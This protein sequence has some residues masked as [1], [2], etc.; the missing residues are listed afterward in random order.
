MKK[1]FEILWFNI[2]YY[3]VL[4]HNR[5]Y[6]DFNGVYL[7]YSRLGL[8]LSIFINVRKDLVDNSTNIFEIYKTHNDT[9]YHGKIT[10]RYKNSDT[11]KRESNLYLDSTFSNRKLV[12]KYLKSYNLI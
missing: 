5:K 1:V 3:R 8:A 12:V 7:T 9:Y 10:K 4:W 11:G 6:D 2:I